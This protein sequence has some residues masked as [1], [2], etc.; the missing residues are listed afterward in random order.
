MCDRADDE[1]D[2]LEELLGI[3]A[4]RGGQGQAVWAAQL[5]D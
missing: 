3:A 4:G 1:C 5:T 2:V